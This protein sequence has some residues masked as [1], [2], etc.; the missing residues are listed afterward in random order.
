MSHME[1]KFNAKVFD[2][3]VRTLTFRGLP[4]RNPEEDYDHNCQG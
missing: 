4:H 1:L 2:L 3:L